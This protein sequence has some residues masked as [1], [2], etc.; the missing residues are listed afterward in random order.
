M[1]PAGERRR[2]TEGDVVD[3]APASAAEM[4]ADISSRAMGRDFNYRFLWSHD[5]TFRW[6]RG[7]R[8]ERLGAPGRE[9][10]ALWRLGGVLT[11]R[12]TSVRF[13]GPGDP[14]GWVWILRAQSG[15][16]QLPAR[17]HG[18]RMAE[19]S[20]VCREKGESAVVGGRG[21]GRDVQVQHEVQRGA[22]SEAAPCSPSSC[23]CPPPRRTTCC[24]VARGRVCM[25]SGVCGRRG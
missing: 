7:E 24:L 9:G 1:L 23:A 15:R 13:G 12:V 25:R 3:D 2:G 11:N 4:A 21:R 16:A 17:Q 18:P 20:P 22:G 19:A 8:P 5:L 14:G 10:E 6:A